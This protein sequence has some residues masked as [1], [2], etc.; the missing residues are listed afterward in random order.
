MMPDYCPLPSNYEVPDMASR[1]R[2]TPECAWWLDDP[3][4][5]A[6]WTIARAARVAAIGADEWAKTAR[7]LTTALKDLRP[8]LEALIAAG[9]A[10]G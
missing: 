9:G 1:G 7:D 5:C 2:C 10:N 8:T 4:A 6:V 3:G